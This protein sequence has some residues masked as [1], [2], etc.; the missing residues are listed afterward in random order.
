VRV[1]RLAKPR[2]GSTVEERLSGEGARLFGGRWTPVGMRAVYC[3]ESSSL[4]AL[5]VLVHLESPRD[6]VPHRIL[7]LEVPD[8][9]IVTPVGSTSDQPRVGEAILA[10]SV[11][12]MVPSA[13]NSL[14]CTVVLNPDHPDFTRV[15]AG[16]MQTFVLD[17]R[18]RGGDDTMQDDV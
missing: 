13:V 18:L 6:F 14:E 17:P 12:M 2:H 1:W 16:E 7:E 9:L 10:D 11:A 5:E 8:E 4:A 15:K 3:S